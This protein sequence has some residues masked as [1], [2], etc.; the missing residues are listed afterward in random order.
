[1]ISRQTIGYKHGMSASLKYRKPPKRAIVLAAGLGTRLESLTSGRPKAL[2]SFAGEPLLF[3]SLRMLASWGVAEILVNAHA[4]ADQVIS[5]CRDFR[6]EGLRIQLSFEPEILGT[7]GALRRAAWFLDS[8]PFWLLN[9]DVVAAVE[10]DALLK[11]LRINDLAV[12]W[13]VPDQGPKTVQWDKGKIT[14]FRSPTPGA[15]GTA[16][17]SGLH[18]CR[19]ELLQFLPVEERFG[20]VIDAYERA[21]KAGWEVAGVDV[22]DSFWA[23]VGTPEQLLDA[24]LRRASEQG[25]PEARNGWIHPDV[26]QHA[27]ARV[28]ESVLMSGV[29][30]TSGA[31]VSRAVVAPG[32]VISGRVERLAAPLADVCT[33]IERKALA[34][35][36]LDSPS[37]SAE[38]LSPRG[39]ARSFFR[40][41]R[42]RKSLMLVRYDPAR[43]ENRD[44]ARQARALH[45]AGVPVF[46][47]WHHDEQHCFLIAEDLG[48]NDLLEAGRC[49]SPPRRRSL[50]SEALELMLCFHRGA[51][52]LARQ[53]RIPLQAPFNEQGF[54]EEQQLFYTSY[55]KERFSD[56]QWRAL[57]P[58]MRRIRRYLAGLPRVPVH[59]DFQSTNIL[60]HRG[61]LRLI[62]FQGMRMGPAVHDAAAFLTDPYAN[63]SWSEVEDLW[64]R[65]RRLY[66]A[67]SGTDRDF[68]IAGVQRLL[69]ALGAYGRLSRLPG[70]AYFQGYI[71]VTLRRLGYC[72]QRVSD[73]P[74]LFAWVE[75]ATTLR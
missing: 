52:P 29:R 44:Y 31:R 42:G 20:S 12:L 30:L 13:V 62:D 10:P 49:A 37:S 72:I 7:G 25:R 11:S 66:P 46:K 4:H 17:F 22:P 75:K 43:T 35:Q 40:I 68:W 5:A 2:V 6:Q 64:L 34:Q 50:Y 48:R 28:T 27:R 51:G 56:K 15:I 73:L 57:R 32:T 9:A 39:S 58:E 55:F 69:Q 36:G 41:Q 54:K 53:G 24:H 3:R 61:C 33:T 71:P 74:Q 59:R 60:L 1:M 18:L 67:E 63:L 45:G 38:C 8:D 26:Q 19:P 23:D 21:M 16:T 14:D 65:F 47:T 70:C